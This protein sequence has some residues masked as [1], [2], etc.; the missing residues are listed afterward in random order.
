[1][2]LQRFDPFREVLTLR[3]AMNRLFEDSVV[4]PSSVQASQVGSGYGLALDVEESGD[5]YTVRAS[6]P[7]FRPEDVQVQV[8]G[9]T[10]SISAQH[11]SEQE[12]NEN[13]YLLRERR[14]G[15][16]SRTITLP[17]RVQSD[18]AQATF[19]NGELVLTL[20]KAE[21]VRPRQI[22]I[23]VQ[24]RHGLSGGSAPR[25]QETGATARESLT[26]ET[27]TPQM[28]QQASSTEQQ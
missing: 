26:S 1:M 6:L 12:R 28:N 2:S 17:Q 23:D 15:S 13:N 5:N 11:R 25:T 4:R 3:D 16:V 9:D 27:A 8:V 21:E 24:G 7:G 20:P 10:L 14:M 18:Q 19:D 22:K